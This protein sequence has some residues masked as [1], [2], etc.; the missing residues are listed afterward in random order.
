MARAEK[1][2][3]AFYSVVTMLYN[4]GMISLST[5]LSIRKPT[6]LFL[7]NVA[8]TP[9]LMA[10]DDYKLAHGIGNGK[11]IKLV[12][13]C[14]VFCVKVQRESGQ[15]WRRT[16]RQDTHQARHAATPHPLVRILFPL[17]A[18]PC[19]SCKR[20]IPG[21]SGIIQLVL[22]LTYNQILIDPPQGGGTFRRGQISKGY[23][24]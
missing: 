13:F 8:Q 12:S 15:E 4:A 9:T 5:S 20:T 7:K 22:V 24:H 17:V 6:V 3:D 1:R 21:T 16:A 19:L 11:T 18:D 10:W 23:S 14:W 2:L